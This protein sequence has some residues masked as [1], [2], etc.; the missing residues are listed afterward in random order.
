[1]TRIIWIFHFL[2]VVFL[3]I[4]SKGDEIWKESFSIPEKGFWGDPDGTSIN[5]D[6]SGIVKWSLDVSACQLT[7]ESDYVKTTATSGGRFEAMDCDGEAI[8]TSEKISIKDFKNILLKVNVSETGSGANNSSKY[9][10]VYY[11]LD[12]GTETLFETNGESAGNF[13]SG[14]AMQSGLNGESLRI[15]IRM[16][17]T[18]ASDKLIVDEISV[19]GGS[20]IVYSSN[21]VS[22]IKIVTETNLEIVFA[23]EIN[24][25]LLELQNIQIID[26]NGIPLQLTGITTN[27][28]YAGSVGVSAAKPSG[29]K[30]NLVV[31]GIFDKDGLQLP[32]DT[33]EFEWIVPCTVQSVVINEIMADPFPSI[34]LPEYEYIELFNRTETDIRLK[35]L[36]LVIDGK[37]FQLPDSTIFSNGYSVL[38]S[39]EAAAY[40]GN[41]VVV[42]QFPALKNSSADVSILSNSDLVIDEVNYSSEWYGNEEYQDGGRSLE[43]I[44]PNRSCGPENNWTASINSVGGTPGVDNSVKRQNIDQLPAK[45]VFMDV[46]SAN[47]LDVYFSEQID[48]EC[49]SKTGNYLI[50]ESSLS[51]DSV[52]VVNPKQ[53]SLYFSENFRSKVNY[54]L[55]MDEL[56]DLCGNLAINKS[57][58]FVYFEPEEHDLVITEIFADPYPSVGLT[59]YEYI[60][61]FNCSEY[62]VQLNNVQ[63]AVEGKS[64]ELGKNIIQPHNYM[65]L[66]S[67]EGASLMSQSL[68]VKSFPSLRNSSGTIQLVFDKNRLIDQ[69]EYFDT[70]YVN[71]EKRDGGWSLERIDNNR[72]CGPAGNWT[73]SV[74]QPGGTPGEQNSVASDNQ[75]NTKPEVVDLEV[76]SSTEIKLFFSENINRIALETKTNYLASPDLGYPV[77]LQLNGLTGITLTFMENFVANKNYSIQISGLADDCGNT[78]E[79]NQ[80]NFT[81]VELSKGEVLISEVLFNPYPGGADFVEIFNHSDKTINLKN[82]SLASR[83][84]KSELKEISRLCEKNRWIEPGDFVLCTKDSLSV[85]LVYYTPCPEC[86]C[87]TSKF[88][89]F[90]DDAGDVVLLD[91]SLAVLD[92]FKYSEKMHHS[93]IEDREGVSLERLSYEASASVVSNWH[94]AASTVGFATPGYANSQHRDELLPRENIVLAPEVFSPNNDG[95]NDRLLIHYQLEEPGYSANVKVY[96]SMGR[97]VNHLVRNELLAQEGEWHW[98]GEKADNTRPGLGIYIVLVELFDMQGNVKKYKKTCTLTDR[99]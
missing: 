1:M 90:P 43:R 89:S 51:P 79:E 17:S 31:D 52:K 75:D 39:A 63:L 91:D 4:E 97:L 60:E 37:V 16:K 73:A 94:S 59:E 47:Q 10:R 11:Q 46:V 61:I 55:E 96:D 78:I 84:D 68:S 24:A 32:T 5:T 9:I 77:K 54:Q 64:Y 36:N 99:L 7:A 3:T 76:V 86:F 42:R 56:I 83:D 15:V 27:E 44:D 40:F 13:G 28:Q 21:H 53:V 45:I 48:R 8:W 22:E 72:F 20:K 58:T 33:I 95:F 65:V 34:S 50:R 92:E 57:G 74:A 41:A 35:Q 38:C 69:L 18:Y 29:T 88:P 98:D 19:E 2:V 49:I 93:L 81:L 70:W 30:M 71:S 66:T 25:S 14:V 67:L 62:P 12:D 23:D 26:E 80:Y 6:M 82:L 87:E 85:S